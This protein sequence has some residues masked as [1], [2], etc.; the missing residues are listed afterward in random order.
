[1][2]VG[3]HCDPILTFIIKSVKKKILDEMVFCPLKV[4]V[5]QR[6]NFAPWMGIGE[7]QK[8]NNHVHDIIF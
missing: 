8:N 7:S 2:F 5:L 1:M 3:K 4:L 6:E